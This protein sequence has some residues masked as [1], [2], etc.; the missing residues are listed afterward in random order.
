MY[1]SAGLRGR[2]GALGLEVYNGS[3]INH[4][5]SMVTISI[6]PKP[7]MTV[8]YLIRQFSVQEIEIEPFDLA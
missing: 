2:R 1:F 3:L 6:L 7:E 4:K 8:A 5:G